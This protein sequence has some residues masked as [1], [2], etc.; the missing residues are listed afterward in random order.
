MGRGLGEMEDTAGDMRA[1]APLG[2]GSGAAFVF[3][4][5]P[6][7]PQRTSAL[8][9]ASRSADRANLRSGAPTS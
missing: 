4:S 8:A 7:E 3:L 2:S 9:L 6:R 1:R 5:E